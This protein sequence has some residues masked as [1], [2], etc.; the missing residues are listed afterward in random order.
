MGLDKKSC[1]SS[2]LFHRMATSDALLSEGE[3]EGMTQ[4]RHR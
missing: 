1:A 3:K 4:D 2:A